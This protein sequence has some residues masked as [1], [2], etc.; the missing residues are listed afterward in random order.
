LS[1]NIYIE[2]LVSLGG[3]KNKKS[4]DYI[5]GDLLIR[6]KKTR[7]EYT[8]KNVVI[9]D[10]GKPY[11]ICYRYYSPDDNDKKVFIKIPHSDFNKFERV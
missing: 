3:K 7:I 5:A 2:A 9:G 10:D 8:V 4:V 11:V 1:K 6:D